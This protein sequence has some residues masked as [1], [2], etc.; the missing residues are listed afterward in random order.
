MSVKNGDDPIAWP[1]LPSLEEGE[2]EEEEEPVDGGKEEGNEGEEEKENAEKERVIR[3]LLRKREETRVARERGGEEEK[4]GRKE[5]KEETAPSSFSSSAPITLSRKANEREGGN[6]DSPPSPTPP[7]PPHYPQSFRE[8]MEMTERG[9]TPAGIAQVESR[10][11]QD[12]EREGGLKPLSSPSNASITKR[13]PWEVAA[14]EEEEERGGKEGVG[15]V[16]KDEAGEGGKRGGDVEN[17]L[18]AK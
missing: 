7:P 18:T 17:E 5:A 3:A 2:E 12:V 9:E 11:S 4:E 14:V 6:V 16:I 1:A 13:K 10:L 8:I 15:E